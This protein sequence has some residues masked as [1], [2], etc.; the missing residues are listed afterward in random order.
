MQ[1]MQQEIA[2]EQGAIYWSWQDAMGGKC[3]M[4]QW[5]AK[6]WAQPDGVHFTAMGYQKI[7]NQ[8]AQKIIQ[9]SE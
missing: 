4:N 7:G 3:T 6:K 9:L 1:K 5:I 8:L 2:Q